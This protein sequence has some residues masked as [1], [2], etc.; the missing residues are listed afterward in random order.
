MKELVKC[1]GRFKRCEIGVGQ[2]KEWKNE[3]TKICKCG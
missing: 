2:L 1:Q 3:S